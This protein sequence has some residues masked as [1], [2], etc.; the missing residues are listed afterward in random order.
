[1]LRTPNGVLGAPLQPDTAAAMMQ[2]PINVEPTLR[3]AHREDSSSL[4]AFL[5]SH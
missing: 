4:N 5:L 2:L 1:V 3:A